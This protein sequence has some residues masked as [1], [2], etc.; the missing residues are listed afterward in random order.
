MNYDRVRH[1]HPSTHLS[2]EQL[3]TELTESK[4]TVEEITGKPVYALAPCNR[5]G[6]KEID[7]VKSSGFVLARTGGRMMNN[8]SRNRFLLNSIGID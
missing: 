1:H 5:V 7:I 6:E 4:N 2:D 8:S 3:K